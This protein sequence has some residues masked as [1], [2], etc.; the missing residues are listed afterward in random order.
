MASSTAVL[1]KWQSAAEMSASGTIEY[2]LMI[3]AA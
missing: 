2:F 3:E 1:H